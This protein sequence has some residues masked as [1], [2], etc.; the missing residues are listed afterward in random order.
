M[1]IGMRVIPLSICWTEMRREENMEAA[2]SGAGRCAAGRATAFHTEC[3]IIRN[4]SVTRSSQYAGTVCAGQ[5]ICAT[6]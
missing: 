4:V 5:Y 2:D 1:P 6:K 3:R